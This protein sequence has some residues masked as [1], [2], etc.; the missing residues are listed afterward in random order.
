MKNTI[1]ISLI[2][3][4]LAILL[5]PA[6]PAAA[7]TKTTCSYWY[8]E[9]VVVDPGDVVVL[10]SGNVHIRGMII[11]IRINSDCSYLVGEGRVV[12][13][14]NLNVSMTGPGGGTSHFV[15]DEGGAWDLVWEGWTINN[16]PAGLHGMANGSLKYE[17]MKAWFDEGP[18][19]NT[20]TVLEH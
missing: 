18:G 2:V 7:A 3:I 5:A 20:I 19:G 8:T 6:S 17:G 1:R 14:E 15:S 12:L 9:M 16:V 4:M 13:D 11:H 10:P